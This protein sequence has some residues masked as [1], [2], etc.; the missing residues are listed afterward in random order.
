MVSR[1]FDMVS[2]NFDMVSRKAVMVFAVSCRLAAMAS[3]RSVLVA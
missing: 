1:N 2:R 3:T